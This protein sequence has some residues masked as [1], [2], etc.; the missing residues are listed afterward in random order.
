MLRN[1]LAVILAY[2]VIGFWAFSGKGKNDPT[3]KTEKVSKS[4]VKGGL[5]QVAAR[6]AVTR[7]KQ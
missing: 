4:T 2:V 5:F 3:V 6:P 1:F 7:V